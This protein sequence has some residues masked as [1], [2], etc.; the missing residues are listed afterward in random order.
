MEENLPKTKLCVKGYGILKSTIPNAIGY[1]KQQCTFVPRDVLPKNLQ[2]DTPT[3]KPPILAWC[4]SPNYLFIPKYMG[5]RHFRTPKTVVYHSSRNDDEPFIFHGEPRV[6][7]Q[8]VIQVFLNACDGYHDVDRGID[9]DIGGGGQLFL[10]TGFGKTVTALYIASQL[11]QKT[12]VIVNTELLNQQWQEEIRRFLKCDVGLIQG[13]VTNLDA[14][15]VIAMVQTLSTRLQTQV[16]TSRDFE[17]FGFT[18]FD[19]CFVPFTQVLT[20]DGWMTMEDLYDICETKN[21]KRPAFV[22][23]FVNGKAVFQEYSRVLRYSWRPTPISQHVVAIGMHEDDVL[24]TPNHKFLTQRGYVCAKDLHAISHAL[25]CCCRHIQEHS[26]YVWLPNPDQIRALVA[27]YFG[28][29]YFRDTRRLNDVPIYDPDIWHVRFSK[30]VGQWE[31]Y[32][33]V[34]PTIQSKKQTHLFFE[35]HMPFYLKDACL[36]LGQ[37]QQFCDLLRPLCDL[38]LLYRLI[39]DVGVYTDYADLE[40]ATLLVYLNDEFSHD[41]LVQLI[42]AFMRHPSL[43]TTQIRLS[44]QTQLQKTSTDQ[45]PPYVIQIEPALS[46]YMDAK[47]YMLYTTATIQVDR[48]YSTSNAP[49]TL[50]TTQ[51]HLVAFDEKSIFTRNPI[52]ERYMYDI[53]I[54][55]GVVLG[56]GL[57]GLGWKGQKGRERERERERRDDRSMNFRASNYFVK[58]NGTAIVV[59]NCDQLATPH[60]STVM[61]HVSSRYTL[62]LSAT[63]KRVDEAHVLNDWYL[64]PVLAKEQ[65]VEI[66]ARV[67]YVDIQYKLEEARR[68]LATRRGDV[69]KLNTIRRMTRQSTQRAQVIAEV[70]ANLVIAERRSVL[71]LTSETAYC[72][73]LASLTRDRISNVYP[74]FDWDDFENHGIRFGIVHGKRPKKEQRVQLQFS[75]VF[76]TYSMLGVGVSLNHLSTIVLA[77]PKPEITQFV[78]RVLRDPEPTVS[79]LIVDV[80]DHLGVTGNYGFLHTTWRDRRARYYRRQ[81]F[82]IIG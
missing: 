77:T 35:T 76:G 81:G 55:D 67:M 12:L 64:G 28:C 43:S 62:G 19:E 7:Q 53:Q 72:D 52:Y 70:V 3:E 58:L 21:R 8:Q 59:H 20:S 82:E 40:N 73:R 78:G 34:L 18:I 57:E 25:V 66:R 37:R 5:L 74:D 60:Y 14:P 44:V 56:E 10:Y 16:L 50:I 2:P 24:C 32:T 61:R 9:R 47:Y 79:P 41:V 45:T 71:I 4:E 13:Q 15:I 26:F 30:N 51:P 75:V 65:K 68:Y 48:F 11:Q 69:D 6:Y 63:A 23:S 22:A 31:Y 46:T 33:S 39:M 80:V 36:C 1:W 17:S 27:L 29:G 38:W 42:L 54:N 49:N